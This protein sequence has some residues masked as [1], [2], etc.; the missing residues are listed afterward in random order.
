[1]ALLVQL[2]V[3]TLAA[4]I[5]DSMAVVAALHGLVMRINRTPS[6][7]PCSAIGVWRNAVT[8]TLDGGPH[9]ASSVKTQLSDW[10]SAGWANSD[11]GGGGGTA[12]QRVGCKAPHGNAQL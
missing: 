4:G 5:Q 6:G 9:M 10:V 8:I 11:I 7:A 12:V 3:E 1:M 2:I